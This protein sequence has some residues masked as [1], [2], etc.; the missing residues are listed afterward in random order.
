[1]DSD[2]GGNDDDD[3]DITEDGDGRDDV[4]EFGDAGRD[5]DGSTITDKKRWDGVTVAVGDGFV[6]GDGF[7]DDRVIGLEASLTI[8]GVVK[9]VGIEDD[10]ELEVAS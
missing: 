10:A 8:E 2:G 5:V 6:I 9:R 4:G 3:G 1:M 7:V